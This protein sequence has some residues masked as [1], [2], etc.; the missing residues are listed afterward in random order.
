M[1]F[2]HDFE[3]FGRNWLRAGEQLG[4]VLPSDVVPE[5][6]NLLLNPPAPLTAICCL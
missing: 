1:S 6:R 4:L 2:D 5:A 3:R